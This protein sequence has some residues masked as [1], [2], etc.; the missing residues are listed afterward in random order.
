[1]AR[2]L[3]ATWIDTYVSEWRRVEL[4][5]DGADLLAAGVPEGPEIGRGLR[6]ARHARIE[7]RVAA[8]HD[9]ELAVALAA[10]RGD[11]PG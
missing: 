4:T 11:R 5:I 8:G 1:M 9:Q 10:A 3:G 6:A 7:G 2:A